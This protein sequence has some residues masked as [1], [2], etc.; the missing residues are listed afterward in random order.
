[1][2]LE[3]VRVFVAVYELESLSAV[4]RRLGR[5]QPAVRHHVARLERE[6]RV[7]LLERRPK[8]VAPTAAGRVL[9]EALRAG[10]SAIH[11]GIRDVERFRDG[12]AGELRITTGGT[13]VRHLLREAVVRFRSR[14][15]DAL[16]RFEPTNSTRQC[17]ETL[18]RD[19]ADLA[20]VS[21]GGEARALE[22]R[23]ALEV[24]FV[25]VA[26][27][28]D[29]RARRKRVEI[30]DLQGLR[31]ISLPT[32]TATYAMIDRVFGEHGIRLETT[33]TVDD[34]D[35]AILFVE[36][37]LGHAIVPA[38]HARQLRGSA[39]ARAVPIAGF[40]AASLGW[41][42]RRW[43]ALTPLALEFV[44]IFSDRARRWRDI[45]GLRVAPPP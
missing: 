40:P 21:I 1:V 37:G 6:L 25:L 35:T 11:G 5:T 24:P 16:L 7:P 31:Y 26:P 19:E 18:L 15:P 4:A 9:Y 12:E 23:V 41:A 30:G 45:P 42:A 22:Q 8:G 10:L 32:R 29:P 13:T 43:A 20:F 14:F 3:D 28:G 17:L 38:I 39:H 27:T 36:L 33:A 44:R 2:T 34:F